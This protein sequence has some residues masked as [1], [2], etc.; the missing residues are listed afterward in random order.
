MPRVV[1]V[2]ALVPAS[3]AVCDHAAAVYLAAESDF[4]YDFECV[5]YRSAQTL[6]V[7][8][9]CPLGLIALQSSGLCACLCV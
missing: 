7:T 9:A 2:L 4:G 6:G 8:V 5:V 3:V 1:N